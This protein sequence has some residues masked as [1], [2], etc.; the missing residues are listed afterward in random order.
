MFSA[1]ALTLRDR[2][3]PNFKIATYDP[4]SRFFLNDI[5]TYYFDFDAFQA[6]TLDPPDDLS[7]WHFEYSFAASYLETVSLSS[8]P[9]S[10]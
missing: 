10:L 5:E 9:P 2:S 4:E 1:G 3:N 7:F 8:F 6:Q